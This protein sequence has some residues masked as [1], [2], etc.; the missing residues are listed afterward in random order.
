MTFIFWKDGALYVGLFLCGARRFF[1]RRLLS[2]RSLLQGAL[3][4]WVVNLILARR[5]FEGVSGLGRVG[6]CLQT[7]EEE[8]HNKKRVLHAGNLWPSALRSSSPF[9][10]LR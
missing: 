10:R 7:R 3:L 6:A 8:A 4:L 5:I 2:R 1:W 9:L